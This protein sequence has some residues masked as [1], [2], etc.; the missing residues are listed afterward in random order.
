MWCFSVGGVHPRGLLTSTLAALEGRR[1][2]AGFP[3]DLHV[4]DHRVFGGVVGREGISL[5]G[6]LFFR[7]VGGRPGDH[8]NWVA[9]EAWASGIAET[10]LGSAVR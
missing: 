4:R 10:L 2:G 1:V 6:R 8:R 5:W 3:V 9:V 7:M